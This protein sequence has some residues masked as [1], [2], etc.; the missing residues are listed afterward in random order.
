MRYLLFFL[1]SISVFA[2]QQQTTRQYTC[3]QNNAGTLTSLSENYVVGL[4]MGLYAW[5]RFQTVKPEEAVNLQKVAGGAVFSLANVFSAYGDRFQG[6]SLSDDEYYEITGQA[7]TMILLLQETLGF[8]DQWNALEPDRWPLKDIPPLV[9]H[10]ASNP[11]IRGHKLPMH[12]VMEKTIRAYARQRWW[13][14]CRR[15]VDRTD[16]VQVAAL[17]LLGQKQDWDVK[18]F[19]LINFFQLNPGNMLVNDKKGF[20]SHR[21]FEEFRPKPISE[22]LAIAADYY[23]PQ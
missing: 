21:L 6:C 1:I 17:E 20:Y 14:L 19:R 7:N 10:L 2:Q 23:L 12:P 18:K 16:P 22:R 9:G 4:Q 11:A 5:S 15:R 3:R 8:E 13:Q